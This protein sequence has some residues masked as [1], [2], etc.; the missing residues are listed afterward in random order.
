[1]ADVDERMRILAE[2]EATAK[3]V[4]DED[5]DE[6]VMSVRVVATMTERWARRA[7][8]RKWKASA[9]LGRRVAEEAEG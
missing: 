7:K 4:R 1:M 3:A 9:R 5:P 6:A 8:E 2:L